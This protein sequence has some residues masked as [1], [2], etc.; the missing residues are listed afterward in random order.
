VS[1]DRRHR[2]ML[3]EGLATD[4]LIKLELMTGEIKIVRTHGLEPEY[5]AAQMTRE[6][7]QPVKVVRDD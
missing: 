7:R 4:N 2:Q 6:L 3:R 5:I 1:Q